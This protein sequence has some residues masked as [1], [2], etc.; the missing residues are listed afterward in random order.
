MFSCILLK[1][2]LSGARGDETAFI[3]V[4]ATRFNNSSATNLLPLPLRVVVEGQ[5]EAPP[6]E[7]CAMIYPRPDAML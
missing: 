5:Q 6:S 7:K 2:G 3:F 4:F 1:T